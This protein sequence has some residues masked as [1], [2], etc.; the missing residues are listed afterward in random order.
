LELLEDEGVVPEDV[1]EDLGVEEV[2]V[3]FV[4]EFDVA[5]NERCKKI[6]DLR[7]IV[8]LRTRL[9]FVLL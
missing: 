3:V 6:W 9:A 1:E 2:L 8:C 5:A 7:I 4:V